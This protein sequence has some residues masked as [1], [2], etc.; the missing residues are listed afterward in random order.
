MVSRVPRFNASDSSPGSHACR[1]PEEVL[2]VRRVV[3]KLIQSNRVNISFYVRLIDQRE[4]RSNTKVVNKISSS[5]K[6]TLQSA[7]LKLFRKIAFECHGV[8]Y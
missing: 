3:N 4:Y 7:G 5:L 1:G 2:I 6:S 8:R